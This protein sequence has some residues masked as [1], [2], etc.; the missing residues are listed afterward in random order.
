MLSI[1]DKDYIEMVMRFS[2]KSER[3][4]HDLHPDGEI[5]LPRKPARS[6]F[7]RVKIALK[8]RSSELVTRAKKAFEAATFPF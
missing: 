6:L 4:E 3:F 5:S 7:R 8:I 1:A 2:K